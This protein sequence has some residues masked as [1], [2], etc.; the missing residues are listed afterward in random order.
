MATYVPYLHGQQ[1]TAFAMALRGIT[2]EK[3]K[4]EPRSIST[5][6]PHLA[7]S[8]SLS[9][10][11]IP[12]PA[13]REDYESVVIYIETLMERLACKVRFENPHATREYLLRFPGLLDVIPKAVDA[14]TKHFP[15][16]Q[17]VVDVYQDPEIADNYL[18][19]YMRLKH[20]DDSVIERLEMAEAE[21]LDQLVNKRGWIQLTTDF[22]EPEGE[23]AL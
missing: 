10:D 23:H 7:Q 14:A 3:I 16:A 19:L 17:I 6:P 13:H 2:P 15:E 9:Q 21:Y 11:E 8:L 12:F 22:R 18:V 20:Y 1:L 4:S 5:L